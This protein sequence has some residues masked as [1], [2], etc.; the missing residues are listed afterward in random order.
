[1]IF[2]F[3]FQAK[4]YALSIE[5]AVWTDQFDNQANRL[6]HLETTGPEIWR[7]TSTYHSLFV[8]KS[9]NTETNL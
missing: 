5:N 6:A 3:F 4:R 7:E 2:F 1:M 8:I 9:K